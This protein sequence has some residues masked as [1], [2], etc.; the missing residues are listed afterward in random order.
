MIKVRLMV[1]VVSF[2]VRLMM[3]YHLAVFHHKSPASQTDEIIVEVRIDSSIRTKKPKQT[4]KH[5]KKKPNKRI[6]GS[7]VSALSLDIRLINKITTI[8]NYVKMFLSLFYNLCII[9]RVTVTV[10]RL[11]FGCNN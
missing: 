3:F 7:L 11:L 6:G 8:I 10:Q 2:S 1:K 5:T 4:N 9:E